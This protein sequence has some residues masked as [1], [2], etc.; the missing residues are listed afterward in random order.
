MANGPNLALLPSISGNQGYVVTNPITTTTPPN[1]FR[2]G[3]NPGVLLLGGVTY[4]GQRGPS[5]C[6]ACTGP[7]TV[8]RVRA[9]N[10]WTW[11]SQY[12]CPDCQGELCAECVV[13]EQFIEWGTMRYR[14]TCHAPVGNVCPRT[15]QKPA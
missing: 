11:Q 8:E 13:A 4:G 2:F 14:V 7:M 12:V 15:L 6:D 3:L 1:N 10:A 5:V 9:N